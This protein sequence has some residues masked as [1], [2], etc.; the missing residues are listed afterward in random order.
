MSAAGYEII[1]QLFSIYHVGIQIVFLVMLWEIFYPPDREKSAKGTLLLV[2]AINLAA[3]LAPEDLG[4]IRYALS[5]AVILLY[6]FVRYK[7]R[8]EKAVFVLLLFYN[9]HALSFLVSD[10]VYQAVID[11]MF[12]GLREEVPGY[13]SQVYQKTAVCEG[14]LF[15]CYTLIFLLMIKGIKKAVPKPFPM[16][17]REAVFLSVLN[18][19]GGILAGMVRDL[20]VVQVEGGV[21]IMFD[22][23]EEMIWKVPLIAFLIYTGEAAAIGIHQSYRRL[24]REK[25]RNYYEKQQVRAL[26]QR[27][28]EAEGFYGN[29][30]KVRHDMANHM[31]ALKGLAAGG[32]YDEAKAYLEKLDETMQ[33]LDDRY[34]TGNAVTDVILNDKYRKAREADISFQVQFSYGEADT[35][36]AFDMGIILNNLLDNAI[37]ACRKL[38]REERYISLRLRR[39]EHFLLLEVENSFD[40]QL[41][42]EEKDKRLLTTKVSGRQEDFGEH[43]IGLQNVKDVAERYLGDMKIKVKEHVFLVTVMLQQKEEHHESHNTD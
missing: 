23:R 13:L 29:I 9:L 34:H 28:E 10:S 3:R 15:L 33:E 40:G 41:K 21:F 30:R 24:L 17:W 7:R 42:W 16:E 22:A 43:G 6:C 37:E 2:T 32:R 8:L 27:L 26:K 18:V 36:P 4:M 39:E 38:K 19:V 1:L 31:A 14:I 35:I 12:R 25:E 20:S 11:G 5:A